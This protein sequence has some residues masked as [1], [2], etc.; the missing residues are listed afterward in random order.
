MSTPTADIQ[1][2]RP[3]SKMKQI[4]AQHSHETEYGKAPRFIKLKEYQY[5]ATHDTTV[6][7]VLEI[8]AST[9]VSLLGPLEHPDPEID[10]YL[11]YNAGRLT[12]ELGVNSMAFMQEMI[13]SALT[14]GISVS[15]NLFDVVSGNIFLKDFAHYD[16]KSIHIRTNIHGRLT[17]G[18]ASLSGGFKSGVYQ[19]A[20]SLSSIVGVSGDIN[21]PLWK[22]NLINHRRRYGNY[23]GTSAIEPIYK[24]TLTTDSVADKMIVALDRFGTPITSIVMPVNST[25][26]TSVDPE[27]GEE[28]PL[29]SIEVVRDT[30]ENQDLRGGNVILIP[31]YSKDLKPEIKSITT[32]NNVGSTFTDT[33]H[34]CDLQKAR[35]LLV[36]L[37]LVGGAKQSTDNESQSERQMEIFH[38][39]VESIYNEMIVPYISQSW[40]RLIRLMFSRESSKVPPTYPLRKTSRPEERVALM[41]LIT[42]LTDRGY[43]VPT[44]DKDWEMIRDWVAANK[45]EQNPNDL[46]FI[47][48]MLVVP[49]TPGP[50]NS[51]TKSQPKGKGKPGRPVGSSKSQQISR[52]LKSSQPTNSQIFMLGDDCEDRITETETI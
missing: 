6:N 47:N 34:F 39:V 36:P 46:D 24:W 2:V 3:R 50:A 49:R 20:H 42:G 11:K 26:E 13:I 37:A 15:E 40:H 21:L 44:N 7:A 9:V 23:Y 17:E 19:S 38:R 52:P 31:M 22:I 1:F 16:P 41:Q 35:G 25:N 8:I 45:R 27:T 29:T 18:E 30:I 5:V 48:N 43:L 14:T 51:K 10:S 28:R 12:N 32:G 4:G 33:I